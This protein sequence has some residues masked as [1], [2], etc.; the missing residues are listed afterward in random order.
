[1]VSVREVVAE[2]AKVRLRLRQKA[3]GLAQGAFGNPRCLQHLLSETQALLL[4]G[5]R[6]WPLALLRRGLANH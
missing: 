5:Y 2:D 1:M 6:R 4:N 3:W